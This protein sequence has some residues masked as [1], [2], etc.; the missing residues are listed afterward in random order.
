MLITEI[1]LGRIAAAEMFNE[2]YFRALPR[3]TFAFTLPFS[4]Q[5]SKARSLCCADARKSPRNQEIQYS[6]HGRHGKSKKIFNNKKQSINSRMAFTIPPRNIPRLSMKGRI[7]F[8]IHP[9][10]DFPIWLKRPW[11]SYR[12]HTHTP[13]LIAL[14]KHNNAHPWRFLQRA[15]THTDIARSHGSSN[16]LCWSNG[17]KAV[18]TCQSPWPN[19][20]RKVF[21]KTSRK[22][23]QQHTQKRVCVQV[24]FIF[25]HG[26]QIKRKWE[27]R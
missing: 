9:I 27:Q 23:R 1:E 19:F 24:G 14:T 26:W 12:T 17:K 7:F 21:D 22:R 8:L 25:R 18:V 15:H 11:K 20:W 16:K 5:E 3:L 4:L 6:W 13:T 2:M 10:D